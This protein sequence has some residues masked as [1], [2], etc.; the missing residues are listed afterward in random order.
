MKYQVGDTVRL[1][2]GGPI[3]RVIEVHARLVTV[4][5]WTGYRMDT[6]TGDAAIFAPAQYRRE[7]LS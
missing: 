3:L 2:S 6:F 4:T 1:K 5:W 7:E